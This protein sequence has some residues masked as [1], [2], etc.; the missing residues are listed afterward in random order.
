M[1]AK[2]SAALW[3]NH[4]SKPET[5]YESVTLSLAV[6]FFS[7]FSV[8]TFI[9]VLSYLE[10]ALA[11]LIRGYTAAQK[12]VNC[13]TSCSDPGRSFSIFFFFFGPN[14]FDRRNAPIACKIISNRF[15]C[16]SKFEN[17]WQWLMKRAPRLSARQSLGLLSLTK[18]PSIKI[19]YR[20]SVRVSIR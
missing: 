17:L 1:S 13:I 12:S 7:S 5:L 3:L 10:A 15:S 9:L 11:V 4:T 6:Y 2:E 18:R 16:M 20:K 19:K 8:W 14:T